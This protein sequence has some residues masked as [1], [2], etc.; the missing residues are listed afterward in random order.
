MALV[1]ISQ[2]NGRVPIT[3]FRLRE[4]IH[5]ENFSK[6]ENLVKDTY[7]AGTRNIII[8]LEQS[9]SLTSIGLRAFVV[10]HKILAQDDN[11]KHLKVA[12]ATTMIREI[13]Q[14]TGISEFIDVYD[15]VEEAVASF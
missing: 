7:Q 15:T 1:E 4:R 10:I 2:A 11:A 8:D 5:L 6:L 14:V 13:M 12:G 3:I 9:N